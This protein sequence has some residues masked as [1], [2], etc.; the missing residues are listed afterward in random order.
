[1][2]RGYRGAD[3]PDRKVGADQ[4]HGSAVPVGSV[5]FRGAFSA[6]LV[7]GPEVGEHGQHPAVAVVGLGYVEF[8]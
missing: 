1:V 8:E 7:Y 6:P 4:D 5:R 2:E 3:E